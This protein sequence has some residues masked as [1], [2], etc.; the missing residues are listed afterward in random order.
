MA[1]SRRD[2]LKGLAVG[3]TTGYFAM[4]GLSSTVMKDMFVPDEP[5]GDVEI[6]EV[7]SIK[8]TVV[9]ETSWFNNKVL[10]GDMMKAGG[11]LVNQYIIPWTR[12]GVADGFNGDN[13][14]GYCTLIDVEFMDG[15]KKKILFDCGWNNAWMDECFRREGVDKMLEK[16]QIDLFFITHE[17]FDHY[18]GVESVTKHCNDMPVIVPHGFYKE[19][20]DLL[21]EKG[22]WEVAGVKNDY[23][24][25]GKVQEFESGTVHKIFPGVASITFDSSIITRVKGE[26]AL[27]F[28][29]HDK[30]L[31][32][33]TGCCHMGIISLLQEVR[34][35]VKGGEK[36]YAIQGGLHISPFEDWDPQYDD[37]IL[38]IP[39]Y[40]IEVMGCNHCTGY[41]TAEKMVK[42]GL[43]VVQGTARFKSKKPLYLG[44]GDQIVFG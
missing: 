1:V 10:V 26:Q 20:Y 44:N 6:G 23:P 40:G 5:V 16:D 29:I 27:V 34:H 28:N 7:K 19:G 24:H 25:K 41:L 4:A 9:S 14:G 30:G 33:V 22:H 12:K 18:W 35:R 3:G 42:A 11:L 37:L 15:T 13:R 43:P 17:H 32:I 36:I 38:A 39:K 21:C 31:A 2:F 8:C